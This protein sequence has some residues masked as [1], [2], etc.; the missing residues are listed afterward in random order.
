VTPCLS[1][2]DTCSIYPVNPNHPRERVCCRAK[3]A[4]MQGHLTIERLEKQ[5]ECLKARA[6]GF[7]EVE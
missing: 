7:R 2:D 6:E 4:Y 1:P 5:C 3:A